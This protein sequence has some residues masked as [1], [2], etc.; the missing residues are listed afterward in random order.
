MPTR[1]P[2]A[3]NASAMARPMPRLP[4]VISA[5]W[6]FSCCSMEF[7]PRGRASCSPPPAAQQQRGEAAQVLHDPVVGGG[8]GGLAVA[9][10]VA[11]QG[12]AGRDR[13]GPV[14]LAPA[15][16][17]RRAALLAGPLDLDRHLP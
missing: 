5:T 7:A 11:V 14:D 6:S 4:P 15:L 1:A 12:E 17:R 9:Q 8:E 3:A 13:R 16:E 2:S 10:V